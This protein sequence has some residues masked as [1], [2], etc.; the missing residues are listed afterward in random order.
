MLIDHLDE[1]RV[2]MQRLETG[3]VAVDVLACRVSQ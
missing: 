1:R 2:V 3:K